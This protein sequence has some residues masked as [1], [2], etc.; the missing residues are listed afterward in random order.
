MTPWWSPSMLLSIQNTP[1]TQGMVYLE[2]CLEFED[3]ESSP[4]PWSTLIRKAQW[5]S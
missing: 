1:K 5:E 3:E 4:K 2:E